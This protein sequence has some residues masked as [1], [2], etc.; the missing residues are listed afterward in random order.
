MNVKRRRPSAISS[1][2]NRRPGKWLAAI[3]SPV[4]ATSST[5]RSTN[6]ERGLRIDVLDKVPC[7]VGQ[8]G[9]DVDDIAENQGALSLVGDDERRVPGRVSGRR[10]RDQ[11]GASSTSES[12]VSSCPSSGVSLRIAPGWASGLS[13]KY[14]Q[15]A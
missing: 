14:S 12:K 2:T 5:I 10:A 15:S 4:C 3:G 11:P 13:T 1:R 7:G 8:L 6:L 9:E